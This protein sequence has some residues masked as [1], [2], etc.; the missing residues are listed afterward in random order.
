MRFLHAAWLQGKSIHVGAV[1]DTP[2]GWGWGG[3]HTRR[4]IP[5]GGGVQR[6]TVGSHLFCLFKH[7]LYT[8]PINFLRISLSDVHLCLGG[9]VLTWTTPPPSLQ[10]LV[11]ELRRGG[12]G[13]FKGESEL[14]IRISW[15]IW[16]HILKWP[17]RYELWHPTDSFDDKS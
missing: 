16:S 9:H 14:K 3:G 2:Q 7:V 17:Y 8:T 5:L 11:P 15:R 12:G 13:L 4:S 10:R 1:M 6:T